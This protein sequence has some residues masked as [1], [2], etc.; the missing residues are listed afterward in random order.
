MVDSSLFAFYAVALP[1]AATRETILFVFFARRILFIF[2]SNPKSKCLILQ[3]FPPP[4]F[5]LF[6]QVFYLPQPVRFVW[7]WKKNGLFNR[8]AIIHVRI[9]YFD[10]GIIAS[11]LIFLF[12]SDIGAVQR[13]IK[14]CWSPY[15]LI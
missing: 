13:D 5:A 3:H 12:G 1:V 7:D 8:T 6:I 15:S 10:R 2:Y 14:N 11:G 9:N 4:R